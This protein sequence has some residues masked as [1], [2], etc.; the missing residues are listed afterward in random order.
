MTEARPIAERFAADPDSRQPTEEKRGLLSRFRSEPILPDAGAGGAPLTAVIAVMSFLACLALAAFIAIAAAAGAW[1]SEL[2]SAVTVQ[3]KGQDAGAIAEETAAALRVLESTEGV[4]EA[5]ALDPAE[6]AKLLEPWLGK[7]NIGEYLNIPAIIEVRVDE[8]LRADL[9]LLRNRLAAAA[10]NAVLDDHGGW[11]GRLSAAARSGL[12][13]AFA[14]FALVMG[15]ACAIAAF[16]ARA[17]LAA[18]REIVS[19]LHLV[20]AT[21]SFI[22]GQVQRRFLTLGVRGAT[23]GLFGAV[24]ALGLAALALR[25]TGAAGDFLPGVA[26]GPGLILPLV[27]VPLVLC[28]V[29]AATARATVLRALVKEL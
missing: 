22:A 24:L 10:P 25:A 19:L 26:L 14:V 3:I 11:H 9:S 18:N 15:A 28:A 17:G 21:D 7:G 13:L 2:K 27:A 29:T 23:A 4:V 5:R 1:T 8:N 20:G 12:A 6:S 16:A